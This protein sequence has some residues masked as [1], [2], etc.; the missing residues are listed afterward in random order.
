MPQLCEVWGELARRCPGQLHQEARH[1]QPL[2]VVAATPAQHLL[3]C[4]KLVRR[5]P[6]AGE[7]VRMREDRLIR[8]H[9]TLEVILPDVHHLTEWVGQGLL[10]VLRCL[11][12]PPCPFCADGRYLPHVQE[13]CQGWFGDKC[14]P[15]PHTQ[16][17]GVVPVQGGGAQVIRHG[18]ADREWLGKGSQGF[19]RCSEHG[20]MVALCLQRGTPVEIGTRAL[21]ALGPRQGLQAARPL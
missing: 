2:R 6:V 17:S 15:A 5:T 21:H 19:L 14:F 1:D 16:G 13:P 8:P 3:R 4:G 7:E 18:S 20:L 10:H 9:R 11:M 12:H